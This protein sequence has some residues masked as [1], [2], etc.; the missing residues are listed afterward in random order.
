MNTNQIPVSKRH[1]LRTR[2]GRFQQALIEP[3]ARLDD[4]GL[5]RTARLLAIFL[6]ILIGLFLLVDIIR[7]LS[8]PGYRPP[9]Y[10]Y[11]L[12]GGAYLL[13]RVGA[14]RAAAG[15]TIAAFP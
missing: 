15:L 1:R 9:W 6:L 12:F 13:T 10:G 7:L 5:R 14:D 2:I 8:M 4:L 3:S 11:L